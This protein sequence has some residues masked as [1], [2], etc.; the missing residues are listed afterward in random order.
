LRGETQLLRGL[1]KQTILS[2]GIK[3]RVVDRMV[4]QGGPLAPYE[5]PGNLNP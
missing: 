4:L 3:S 5:A 1:Q 2:R